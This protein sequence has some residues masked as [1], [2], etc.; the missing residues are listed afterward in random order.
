[1]YIEGQKLWMV[2]H[3]RYIGEPREVTITKVGR[4]WLTLDSGHRAAVDGLALDGGGGYSSPGV[5]YL[6]REAWEADKALNDAWDKLRK[7]V[8]LVRRVPNA[9][10]VQDIYDA[11]KLLRL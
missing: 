11:R 3:Q 8:E 4:K 7:D 5:C 1:M 10:A 2:P 6:T 9:I